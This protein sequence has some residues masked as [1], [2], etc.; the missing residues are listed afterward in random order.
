M[1]TG[2]DYS[3]GRP[4]PSII[5]QLGHT[6]VMR[7]VPYPGDQGKGLSLGE[8]QDLVAVGLH[9]GLVFESTASRPLDGH[10]AGVVDAQ[11][12]E[13]ALIA[14]QLPPDLPV[15]FAVDFDAQPFQYELVDSY[16]RGVASVL[17]TYRVGVYGGYYVV[18][19]LRTEQL[20]T[21]YWQAL[22]WSGG[23]L[24]RYAHLYQYQNGVTIDNA[25]VDLNE[26]F[27]SEQGLYTGESE[28][29]RTEYEDL[30][31]A[32]YSGK[33]E[34]GLSREKRLENALYRMKEAVAGRAPSVSERAASAMAISLRVAA[35]I[36]AAGLAINQAGSL[37]F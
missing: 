28:V 9:V 6:F 1:T 27:G 16:F 22:A 14:L 7:Y 5:V 36:A 34:V 35:G 29:T 32:V 19:H 31:I 4:R 11:T 17:G 3:W 2:L 8:L 12:A 23:H 10:Q 13:R 26:S 18:E 21:W 20:A 37:V 30:V 33:E 24:S 25:A 15:Y